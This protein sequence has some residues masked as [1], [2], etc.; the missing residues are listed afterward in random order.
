[1]TEPTSAPSPGQGGDAGPGDGLTQTHYERLLAISRTL[2][3][4]SRLD[5]LL[6]A[7][8]RAAV[9]LVNAEAASI[10][11]IK[12][13]GDALSLE[14]ALGPGGLAMRAGEVPLEASVAG[15][16]VLHDEPLRV[17][18]AQGEGRWSGRIGAEAPVKAHSVLAVPLRSEG[19]V[20]GCL[21]VFNRRD[22]GPFTAKDRDA[23]V[24]LAA[25]ADPALER[26]RG[27]GQSGLISEMVHELR[28]PLAAIKATML[29]ILRPEVPEERRKG[30][31]DT[32]QQ[33]TD[34]LARM[35]SDFV[36]LARLESGRTRLRRGPVDLGAVIREAA[37]LV[38]PQAEAGG[39]EVAVDVPDSLP[40]AAGDA[41][42]MRQVLLK[43]IENAIKYNRP[44]GHV[45]VRAEEQAGML[46]VE[47]EDDGIGIDDRSLPFVFD[48]LFRVVTVEGQSPGSGL[49]LA[50]ARCI[51]ERHG[52]EIGVESEPDAGSVFW[53]TLPQSR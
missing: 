51:V 37:H 25:Q 48:R 23:L 8:V 47:V 35:A 44:G 13:G 3:A 4:M 17:D 2:V 10:L 1:M 27:F 28:T 38:S 6:A 15:W 32:V 49:G 7:I 40:D 29:V 46:R 43:L 20:T 53:F 12:A 42:Q 21:E 16:V 26:A 14:V 39:V 30:M 31:V 18:D 36:A 11:S 24:A 9:D 50:I 52:G 33:E 41:E 5:D 34:R 19:R 45:R 22:G